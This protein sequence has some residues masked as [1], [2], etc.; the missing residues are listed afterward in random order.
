[1]ESLALIVLQINGTKGV[2]SLR[3]GLG[4]GAQELWLQLR[5]QLN[6][7]SHSPALRASGTSRNLTTLGIKG[8]LDSRSHICRPRQIV[9]PSLPISA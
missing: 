7:R 9:R 6:L 2:K 8:D 4:G 5:H 1:M 3:L